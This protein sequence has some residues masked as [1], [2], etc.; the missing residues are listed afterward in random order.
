M[1]RLWAYI[2]FLFSGCSVLPKEIPAVPAVPAIPVIHPE[3]LLSAVQPSQ[4]DQV[5]L[6]YTYAGIS[7]FILGALTSAFW[8]KKSGLILILAG[9]F[10]GAVP[11]VIASSYFAW[12]SA[13]TLLSLAVCG[14]WWVR[15]KVKHE[16]EQEEQEDNKT[17]FHCAKK[18]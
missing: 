6:L 4:P 1:K 8:D 16:A 10:C 3:N 2:C 9:V 17:D 5:S 15:W 13:G 7:L 11:F 14:V 18:K 12:I